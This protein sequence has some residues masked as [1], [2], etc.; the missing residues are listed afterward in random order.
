MKARGTVK[1]YNANKGFG[2]IKPDH[3][4]ADVFVQ[5]AALVDSIQADDKVEYESA[6]GPK[7]AMALNVRLV[8]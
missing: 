5:G 3:G 1:F 7:V 8:R 6:P 4:G 2:F